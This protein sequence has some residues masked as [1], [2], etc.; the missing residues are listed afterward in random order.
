MI[1][2]CWGPGCFS[3]WPRTWTY[4]L[5][6]VEFAG[7]A[8]SVLGDPCG[9]QGHP[10]PDPVS[11][12]HPPW[13][14][15]LGCTCESPTPSSPH[16]QQGL[17]SRINCLHRI[18]GFRLPSQPL[19]F[20]GCGLEPYLEMF[21]ANSRLCAR[22]SVLALWSGFTPGSVLGAPSWQGSGT[23]WYAED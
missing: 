19:L 13:T 4:D 14:P 21:R 2:C 7:L 15:R 3:Q 18:W 17:A 20:W 22:N 6:S 10:H 11:P 8:L 5:M 9:V 12:S 1:L 16:M 23:L